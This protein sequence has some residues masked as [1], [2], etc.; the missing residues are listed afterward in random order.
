MTE[1]V[2]ITGGSG[3]LA[4]A[5]ATTLDRS[6]W[7]PVLVTRRADKLADAGAAVDIIEADVSTE[8]GASEAHRA[9]T[10]RFGLP[11]A[12]VAA[13]GSTLIM[14]LHRTTEAQ[15]RAVLSANLDTAYYAL[16][17]FVETHRSAGAGRVDDTQ[18]SVPQG[19]S[20][21]LFSTIVARVGVV[22][23]EAIAA[24]KGALEALARSAAAT[25]APQNIR[26][27]VLAPGLMETPLAAPLLGSE[28]MRQAAAR[29]YPIGGVGKAE[30]VAS[31]VAWLLSAP[32]RRV[33]GQVIAVDGG[34]TAIRPLI[35]A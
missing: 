6:L 28:P 23:H 11:R 9:C 22:N 25:Y 2:L 1:V 4:R 14:P 30:E 18:A 19:G 27:N 20:V 15:Y 8:A 5:L 7:R 35:R 12:L 32:A 26:V 17:A 34:F 24:A 13:A 10:E 21:V 29:Q 16:R 3:G 33:T 31:L